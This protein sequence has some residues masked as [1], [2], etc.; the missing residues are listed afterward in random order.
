MFC[1]KCG[2]EMP[3]G[4]KFCTSCGAPMEEVNSVPNYQQPAGKKNVSFGEAVKLFFQNYAN[5]NGRAS[6]NEFWYAFLFIFIVDILLGVVS[7]YLPPLSG[8][9]SLA[10]F[11]PN[12]SLAVRRLHDT[13]KSWA[14]LLMV[15][16]P[17]VGLIILLVQYCKDSQ[18]D[19]QWG[20]APR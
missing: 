2:Q 18:P 1:K 8:L 7:T 4:T 12:L 19:N 15:L 13:G 20:P 6:K 5:F 11:I 16:I 3:D 17:L 14:Y 10:L 9:I